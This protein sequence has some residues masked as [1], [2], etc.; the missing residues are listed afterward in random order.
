MSVQIDPAEWEKKRKLMRVY[1]D[2]P[3]YISKEAD[4]DA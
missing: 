2:A 3:I 4:R 1:L